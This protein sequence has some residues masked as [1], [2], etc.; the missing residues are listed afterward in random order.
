MNVDVF[1]D[2][3][4][5]PTKCVKKEMTFNA[6]ETKVTIWEKKVANGEI[7]RMKYKNSNLP[8]GCQ[9]GNAWCNSLIPT[10]T[11][12]VGGD[13]IHPW[14]IKD[15]AL[16]FI[17]AKTWKVVYAGKPTLVNYSIV[18]GDAV[19]YVV[20]FTNSMYLY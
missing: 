20:C 8:V 11:H 3:D 5:L 10:I 1:D 2:L 9:D 19:Y 16:I 7:L 13:N 12:A 4:I 18:P 6:S 17:L 14:L 15:D